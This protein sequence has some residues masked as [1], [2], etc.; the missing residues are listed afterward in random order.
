MDAEEPAVQLQRWEE[1]E[2]LGETG[3][4]ANRGRRGHEETVS[5]THGESKDSSRVTG[6]E[7]GDWRMT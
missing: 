4:G 7:E 1:C 6:P 5:E 3:L 2:S